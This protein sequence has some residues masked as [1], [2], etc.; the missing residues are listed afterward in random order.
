MSKELVECKL[1]E[2]DI[3]YFEETSSKY[4]QAYCVVSFVSPEPAIKRK[5][6]NDMS[7]FVFYLINRKIKEV[8]DSVVKELNLFISN[9][10]DNQ[11]ENMN[12]LNRDL[13]QSLLFDESLLVERYYSNYMFSSTELS[14]ILSEISFDTVSF[15][16][17]CPIF[18]IKVH[19]VYATVNEAN[20]FAQEFK[21][22]IEPN[23]SCF[24]G[25]VGHWCPFDP[26]E[27]N[28]ANK[29][30]DATKNTNPDR[31][32]VQ[33]NTI[34]EGYNDNT[35]LKDDFINQ[36][37]KSEFNSREKE[38]ELMRKKLDLLKQQRKRK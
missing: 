14:E 26:N 25:N 22:K 28:I 31:Q 16:E 6:V 10:I 37:Q 29:T 24:V 20:T 35:I 17:Q 11:T 12:E 8:T 34:V 33:F 5:L 3:I 23:V 30:Y 2:D 36:Q 38:K 1:I 9:M 19:G 32:D 18:G 4:S 13:K 21:K 27:K 15:N 7:K